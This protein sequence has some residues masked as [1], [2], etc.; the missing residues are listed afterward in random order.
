[1]KILTQKTQEEIRK[2]R[3]VIYGYLRSSFPPVEKLDEFEKAVEALAEISCDCGLW[4]K[5]FEEDDKHEK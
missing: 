5:P 1:M 4:D 2:C 3:N